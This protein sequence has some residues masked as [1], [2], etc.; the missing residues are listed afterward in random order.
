MIISVRKSKNFLEKPCW[1][2]HTRPTLDK[3][4]VDFLDPA[5]SWKQVNELP[6]HKTVK[7]WFG[8]SCW[9]LSCSCFWKKC[10]FCYLPLIWKDSS[11]HM[12][13]LAVY[14]KEGLPFARDLSL[15]NSAESYL[16][17]WLALL[18]SVS[19]FFPSIDDL[20]HL[21]AWF[22]ILFYVT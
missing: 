19:Y 13:G 12:H 3:K 8:Q 22:L 18:H 9:K 6:C 1:H 20:L 17:F 5:L 4:S 7:K 2:K 11:T 21:Y 14:F 16:L 10:L 15:E